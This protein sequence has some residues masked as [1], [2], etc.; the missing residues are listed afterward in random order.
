MNTRTLTL[1]AAQAFLVHE[2]FL[3]DERRFEEWLDLFTEDAVYDVPIN[4]GSG[5]AATDVGIIHDDRRRLGERV[6]RLTSGSAHAEDPPHRTRH[7]ITNVL[8]TEGGDDIHVN[9][10]CL[11]GAAR[12]GRERIF[13]GN[14]EHVLRPEGDEW[15]IARKTCRLLSSDQPV[16]NLTFIL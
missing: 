7:L 16:G 11:I 12:R 13:I 6:Y 4:A 3:I 2:A 10:N 15:R 5:S 1:E 14:Y 9:S 8:L